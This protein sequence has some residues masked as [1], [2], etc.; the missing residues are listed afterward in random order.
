[1]IIVIYSIVRIFA[2]DPIWSN[3]IALLFFTYIKTQFPMQL[4]WCWGNK[5]FNYWTVALS[6]WIPSVFSL[7]I[8]EVCL[9]NFTF[10]ISPFEFRHLNLMFQKSSLRFALPTFVLQILLNFALW[11]LSFKFFLTN[12]IFQISPF[13]F[14]ILSLEFHFWIFGA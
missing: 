14:L 10:W 3:L 5:G 4:P 9:S 13:C 12:F 7:S 6:S 2:R 1:M 11:I 8:F